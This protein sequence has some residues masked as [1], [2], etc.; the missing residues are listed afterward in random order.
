M[1]VSKRS[2][3]TIISI[4]VV[5]VSTIV[6]IILGLV[7]DRLSSAR[8]R[9][10][11]ITEEAILAD[12]LAQS[13]ALPLWNF[14]HSQMDK[15]M[16]SAMQN[17]NIF[18]IAVSP[19]GTNK[20][21]YAKMR[22]PEWR[23]IEADRASFPD[24]LLIQVREIHFTDD[25]IGSVTIAVTS[26]FT[27]AF[28]AH[29]RRIIILVLL[30]FNL[31]LA[32]CL[33]FVLVRWVVRP[34]REVESFAGTVSSGSE[35][36]MVVRAAPYYGE[37][38]SVRLSIMKM[39]DQLRARYR[40]LQ[41]VME[42]RRESEERFRTVYDA[43]NDAIFI[44]DMGTGA[45]LDVNLKMCHMYGLT[46]EEALK[47]DIGELSSG[48]SPF[49]QE[50]AR[51]KIS[52]AA[53][54]IPQLFEWHAKH[55][56]GHLFWVEVNMRKASIA[57]VDRAIV[58]VRD[59]TA[60]KQA[61]EDLLE[62]ER[63]YRTLFESAGDSI[64]LMQGDRFVECNTR[65]LEMFG[66]TRAQ[67]IGE[68]P[69][70]FS[71]PEQPD[72]RASKDKALEK[73]NAALAGETQFFEW[74]HIKYDG[75]PFDAEVSL[76]RIVLSAGEHLQAIVRDI[77]E[78]KRSEQ[79]IHDANER[80]RA[81]FQASPDSISIFRLAEKSVYVDTNQGFTDIFGYSKAE[82]LGKTSLELHLWVDPQDRAPIMDGLKEDG[83]I[84]NREVRFRSKDGRTIIASLSARMIT[85][86]NK[87]HILTVTR[88][89]TE[90]KM[91]EEAI[92]SSEEKLRLILENAP[93]AVY[94]VSFDGK[95]LYVN[96]PAENMSGYRREELLRISFLE[97]VHPEDR[98]ALLKKRED[99]LAGNATE[100]RYTIRVLD[101]AGSIHWVQ[102]HVIVLPW[103][104]QPATLNFL[105]DI[106][107][108]K[109]AEE[110]LLVR[111]QLL[112]GATDSIFLL[113]KDGRILYANENACKSRG[114]SRD[115]MRLLNIRDIVHSTFADGVGPRISEIFAKGEVVFESAHIRRDGVPFPVE[116]SVRAMEIGS[117][118][119]IIS[120]VRDITERK[121]AE[122]SLRKSEEMFSK[123]FMLAPVG[124][125]FTE[126][127]DGR[128]V[129]VNNEFERVF[130][131][132]RDEAVGKTGTE[133]GIWL[134]PKDREHI[135]RIVRTEGKVKDLDIQVRGKRGNI[136]T[137]RY[138]A[139]RIELNGQDYLLAASMD[140]TKLKEGENALR[141]MVAQ[142]SQSQ[143]EWQDTFDSITDMISI[144]DKENNIIRANKAFS[145]NMGLSPHELINRKCYDLMHHG[146]SSP[147][148][149]CS[150][151]RTLQD[152][153]PASEEVYDEITKKTFGVSTFPY[154]S[155]DGE[156]IGSI[157]IARD[158][159]E[160][161]EREIRMIMT[162]RLASL[163][164]MAS[165]IAHEINNPLESVMICAEILLM[166]VAKDAYDRAQFEKYLKIIDEEVLRCR[167]ITSNMLS[168]S[169]QTTLSRS[170]IDVHLLLDKA[171]DLLGY[172]GRLKNVTVL[173]KYGE[174]ILASGNEGELRQVL[175]VLLI[176]ALDAMENKGAITVETGTGTGS[177][178]VRISDTGP[179]IAPENL[180]RI[181]NPFFSTKT[182]KGGTGLGL[183]IAHR[184][185]ANHRGSL[186]VVS[187]QGR[188]TAFTITLPR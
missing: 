155:P 7:L 55:K 8:S 110:E 93:Y 41:K 106:T 35:E 84:K 144:H 4:S 56:D 63:R 120:I 15:I 28:L 168:F 31:I 153:T 174:K 71:P 119:Y 68:A 172:Q 97:L 164:Q 36:D 151:L 162:E 58:V 5:V 64:F 80:F 145:V 27:E 10:Q 185:I 67:I 78:R 59:I 75:T 140:I 98:G 124:I 143:K 100:A 86:D 177:V 77:S 9:N 127:A 154:F 112:D 60:R 49:T 157:H 74:K 178:W 121:R 135:I 38:E 114:Y 186:T 126:L 138:N 11:L 118:K 139:E 30:P 182:D 29:N 95:G 130:G 180:Q 21:A 42:L 1:N 20:R 179:G 70:R 82:V 47:F 17:K 13:L 79:V 43:V 32:A 115:E 45:I 69:Y 147:I 50:D 104:G 132:S 158:I 66:C 105:Q 92:K 156:I 141:E 166:R 12:Q 23:I 39:V 52:K 44:H 88:D 33:Y 123:L 91:A 109:R 101:K 65:T 81:A 40:N 133:L 85:L 171:T 116:T 148:A 108:R 89:I 161:K 111:A 176:N 136:I 34:L 76:N 48:I 54:G 18:G 149:G 94:V 170:D 131:F 22:D 24:G 142:V 125:A 159:T 183:S 19:S 175:L 165:G 113:D 169:R 122:E 83:V 184:I 3:A 2:V 188:G 73:I 146:A 187:E 107:E 16:E 26:K 53:A 99:R 129:N 57:G 87:P 160:E 102:N 128:F 6:M 117:M 51:D 173:K 163:G 72:G 150:H 61:E 134:D 90:Q 37:L 46:R 96:K 62:S 167:D 152:R 103:E 14:D 25:P 137:W 181:F